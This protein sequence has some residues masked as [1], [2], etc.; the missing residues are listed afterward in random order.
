MLRFNDIADKVLETQ[1][2][3]DLA[4]LQ[5]AYVFA[6]KVHEGQQRLSGEPYLVHP[7]EVGGILAE[8][9]LDEATVA[10]GLLHDT[11]ED[12]L[13]TL[14]ELRRLF[15][16]QVAFLVEGLTKIAKIEFTSARERQAENFRK[17]LIAM[18]K[19]IRILLIKLADRLHNMRTLQH[20]D[21]DTRQR[22]AQETMEIYAPLA[23]RLGIDWMRRELVDLA[24]RALRPQAV[25]EL[26]K[27]LR[28]QRKER[29][30][31]VEEVIGV[32]SAKLGEAELHAEVTGREKELASIQSKM[33]S[34][35]I[36]L[37]QIHDVIAFRIILDEPKAAV[38]QALGIVHAIWRPVPGRFKDY[39]ALPKPNGYQSLHT[40]V[41]GSSGER[42]EI[43]IRTRDMHRSAE[44]GIA[45][46]WRYKEGD[47]AGRSDDDQK[48]AWLRQLVERQQE[49]SDPHEFLDTVKVD[50][51]PDEVFVFTPRGDV[52]AL[53][54]GGTPVDFAYAIHSE[55]GERCA[56]ARVNGKLVALR[57]PLADGD[58][59]E[60]LTSES[61]LP[62][63]DWLE[64]V[65]SGKAR[66]RIR[67]AIRGAE[68]ARSRELGRDILEK[69]LR[70]G[71]L[72]L[73]RAL[74][75]GRLA[76][77]A[78]V[79]VSGA[80]D[81][82]F[83]AVGYGRIPAAQ[84]LSRL[85]G[86]AAAPAAPEPE[87]KR[88]RGLFRREPAPSSSG[89][90]VNGQPDVLVRFAGCC[91]PIPGDEVVG[92]VTRGRGVTVHA[93]DC[94]HS[95]TQDPDRRID[96][97]WETKTAVPRQIKV[98]IVSVDQ[99]GLLAKITKSIS[100]VGVN[101]GGARVAIQDDRTAVH[102]FDL[103]VADLR[104]LNTVMKE[105]ERVRG[106]LSVERVR[107]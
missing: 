2:D 26:E 105:I 15:G 59:V 93:R 60:I 10:A 1:P 81:D 57:H 25:E 67:H 89:V 18:S 47:G 22:I 71:G 4:L 49:L 80:P 99:P 55:V 37:D 106:V 95:F 96:V 6:A 78:R 74:E 31:Y 46:H 76:E 34:Q 54:R 35:G 17:M 11:L 100:S 51:F 3:A 75:D 44:F 58:T 56:G 87:R 64:F 73:A 50:L 9:R 82:L 12:T 33:E 45:A 91:N 66:Q 13:T 27:A 83:S 24:F 32:L 53:P 69:E 29:A 40:T 70:R 21:D 92:F 101:I 72:S 41:I 98:R 107:A 39:V 42:M 90:R 68:Q 7:L 16:D 36:G 85:R 103:W 38:Y 19:D 61:Q 23:H 102:D 52:I 94:A 86:D 77:V 30:R 20:V 97:D 88:R 48:F 5:R 62:R 65:V 79:E 8:M 104:A 43:Q 28:V 14:P 84:V 63:K